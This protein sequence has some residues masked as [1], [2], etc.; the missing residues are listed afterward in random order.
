MYSIDEDML[1]EHGKDY[2]ATYM[3][4]VFYGPETVSIC[5]RWL[6]FLEE[7]IQTP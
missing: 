6:K 2:Y 4:P 1:Y 3:F 5:E 7:T